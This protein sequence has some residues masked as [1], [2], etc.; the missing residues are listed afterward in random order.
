MHTGIL[1]YAPFSNDTE[2]SEGRSPLDLDADRRVSAFGVAEALDVVDT[3]VAGLASPRVLS[4]IR[5][6][7]VG[8]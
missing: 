3:S 6:V 1:A 7:R 4:V 2:L 5:D 8:L